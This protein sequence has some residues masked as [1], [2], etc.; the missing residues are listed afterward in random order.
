MT[1][2]A[3]SDR[4]WPP[5]QRKRKFDGRKLDLKSNQAPGRRASPR[6]QQ[7]GEQ[8]TERPARSQGGGDSALRS[9]PWGARPFCLPVGGKDQDPRAKQ[10]ERAERDICAP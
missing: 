6:P 9:P 4:G 7:S 1:L 5:T 2:L 8:W 3:E 10:A